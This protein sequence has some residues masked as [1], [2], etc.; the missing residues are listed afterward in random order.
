[1]NT[2]RSN[3]QRSYNEK[4]KSFLKYEIFSLFQETLETNEKREEK[5]K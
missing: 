3:E 5:I 2:W 4:E 1:M